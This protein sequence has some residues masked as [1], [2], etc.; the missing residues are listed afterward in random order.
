MSD[1][2]TQ[3]IV[4]RIKLII[5][6]GY[7]LEAALCFIR[8]LC[9][10][11]PRQTLQLQHLAVSIEDEPLMM[12]IFVVVICHARLPSQ[13]ARDFYWFR[14]NVI[15]NSDGKVYMGHPQLWRSVVG[16][17]QNDRR[18]S[19]LLLRRRSSHYWITPFTTTTTTDSKST[20]W[21]RRFPTTFR[22]LF[23]RE[24]RA[25]DARG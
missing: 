7:W 13:E 5:C 2:H 21:Q 18:W 12:M 6:L 22:L 17:S 20:L 16:L 3:L 14:V 8:V 11:N 1:A 10:P 19:G 23:R 24:C 4:V 15:G 25:L 9:I